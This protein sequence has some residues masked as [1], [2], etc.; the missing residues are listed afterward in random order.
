MSWS[1]AFDILLFAVAAL[2]QSVTGY[3]GWRVTVDGGAPVKKKKLYEGLF[4]TCVT[5]GVLATIGIAYR[6]GNIGKELEAI[7]YTQSK[8]GSELHCPASAGNGES[9][10][11]LR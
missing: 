11:P 5:L 8:Q 6:G 9:V 3:L 2:S 1:L 4:L 10:H 7:K